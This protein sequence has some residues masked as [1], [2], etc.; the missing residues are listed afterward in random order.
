MAEYSPPS[1]EARTQQAPQFLGEPVSS[2]TVSSAQEE[3]LLSPAPSYGPTTIEKV[4]EDFDGGVLESLTCN[5]KAEVPAER[6]VPLISAAPLASTVVLALKRQASR[7]GAT[8]KL[9][10]VRCHPSRCEHALIVGT[11][12]FPPGKVAG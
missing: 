1:C 10:T 3:R 4:E 5:W 2:L 12:T 9:P 6:G 7:Q 8:E 11:P